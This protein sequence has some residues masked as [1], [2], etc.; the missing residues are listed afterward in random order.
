VPALLETLL[1]Y[2]LARDGLSG[3]ETATDELKNS[4][5]NSMNQIKM[6][7][8]FLCIRDG[9]VILVDTTVDVVMDR[10]YRKFEDE[11]RV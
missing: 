4:L 7:A 10:L 1:I 5:T 3:L 11:F 6:F 2:I 8:D 9:Q